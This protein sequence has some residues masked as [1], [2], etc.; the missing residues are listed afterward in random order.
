MSIFRNLINR[1][2]PT[3]KVEKE[4]MNVGEQIEGVRLKMRSIIS[5]S[6]HLAK[7]STKYKMN[8]V[9]YKQESSG[10]TT[11]L[12]S[13]RQLLAAYETAGKIEE[14][15]KYRARLQTTRGIVNRVARGVSMDQMVDQINKLEIGIK[16]RT[17][18]TESVDRLMDRLDAENGTLTQDTEFNREMATAERNEFVAQQ[19][20]A[21]AQ[22]AVNENAAEL[23]ELQARANS[24]S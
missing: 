16:A 24:E 21:Q 4:L 20:A 17:G 18:N 11:L 14:L 3:A 10:L 5:E 8:S 13:E 1:G 15:R 9:R 22:P 6:M 12:A 23:A 2:N 7:D 19:A